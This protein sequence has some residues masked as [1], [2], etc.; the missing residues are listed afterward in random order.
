MVKEKKS[1]SLFKQA[2]VANVKAQRKSRGY[3]Q[4]YI[5][6]ILSV[7]E[8]YIGQIEV[9]KSPSMYTYEQLNIIAKDF[10]CSPK[11]FMPDKGI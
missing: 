11:D 9:P 7:T 1:K 5:A 2:I 6:M 10:D 8:G 4:S 3:P